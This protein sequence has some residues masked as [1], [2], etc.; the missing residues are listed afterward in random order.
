MAISTDKEFLI[1]VRADIQQAVKDMRALTKEMQ[2]QGNAAAKE[3]RQLKG[4]E[5]GYR[6]LVAAAGAYVSV[7]TAIKALRIADEYQRIQTQI[8]LATKETGDYNRVSK[9][10][11]QISQ[12]NSASLEATVSVFRGVARSAKELKASQ[13]D[14]LIVTEAIQQ[15]FAQGTGGA[16]A[17]GAQFQLAQ[18]FSGVVVQAQE[19]NSLIDGAPVLVDAITRGLSQTKLELRESIAA[20]ELLVS[21]V[22]RAILEQAPEI[23]ATM[24]EIPDNLQKSG[25]RLAN[26]VQLFL[27]GLDQAAGVTE[28]IA[29]LF[30]DMSVA[31]DEASEALNPTGHQRINALIEDRLDMMK[32]IN[33]FEETIAR[34]ERIPP[35]QRR[36]IDLMQMGLAKKRV[37]ELT[38]QINSAG[39]ELGKLNL[40]FADTGQAGA[41]AGKRSAEQQ[42]ELADRLNDTNAGLARQIKLFNAQVREIDKAKAATADLAA[43]FD[44]AF[45]QLQ[46][47]GQPDEEIR[48]VDI[49]QQLGKVKQNLAASE[50]DKAVK[51]AKQVRDLILDVADAGGESKFVLNFLLKQAKAIGLEASTGIEQQQQATLE[52]SKAAITDLLAQAQ[53]LK[54]LQV[55]FDQESASQDGE[56]LRATLQ[57]EFNN[58]PLVLPVILQKVGGTEAG[59]A[60]KALEGLEAKAGGGM[61]R[62]PGSGTSDNILARL[63]PGEF[64]LR[65]RA[66]DHYGPKMLYR[67]NQMRVPRF[68]D[69]GLATPHQA[70]G[71]PI[72][73][74]SGQPINLYLDGQKYQVT[75]SSQTVEQ[76]VHGFRLEALKRGRRL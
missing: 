66:V 9:Q 50:F 30:S 58:H 57:E 14:V 28:F 52:Q 46:G 39:E 40:Q 24:G 32:K 61:L 37:Q 7:Q 19:F 21:D 35:K 26:S 17:A 64:V 75:A 3:N 25:T 53:E 18:M 65:K 16:A 51:G 45:E 42:T 49:Q 29:N 68:A 20:G 10:L 5:G 6:K 43:S 62:G 4:L 47:A 69:G 8:K 76:M 56:F 70:I 12:R 38:E 73:A 74:S 55:G 22:F 72:N 13:R 71:Q 27:S 1:R 34:I 48:G 36:N 23:A 33:R 60:N 31:M 2:G 44:T 41:E 67:M 54:S 11:Y 15:T 59:L 63:S